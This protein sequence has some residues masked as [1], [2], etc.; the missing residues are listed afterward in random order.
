MKKYLIIEDERYPDY[1]ITK[2]DDNYKPCQGD[3]IVEIPQDKVDWILDIT[4]KYDEVQ[5]YLAELEENVES[6]TSP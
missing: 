1:D 4:Y 2:V 5:E 6:K 3:V